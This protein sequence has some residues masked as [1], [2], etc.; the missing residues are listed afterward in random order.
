[1][2]FRWWTLPIRDCNIPIKDVHF[3][4]EDKSY[5]DEK[6]IAQKL[7]RQFAHPSARNLEAVMKNADAVDSEVNEIIEQFSDNCNVCKM[8]Q[9]TPVRP[10]VCMPV[11]NKFNEVVAM[12][13]KHFK[14]GAYLLHLIDLFSRFSLSKVITRKLPSVTVDALNKMWIA[15]GFG[16]PKGFLLDNGGEFAD[17]LY[18]EMTAHFNV[19]ICNTGAESPWQNGIC[20]RNHVVIDLCVENMLEDDQTLSLEVALAWVMNAKNS[21]SYETTLGFHHTN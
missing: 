14:D 6:R 9:R 17:N 4:I 20:N 16:A 15:S 21:I 1:M 3:S 13:L 5:V 8:F 2:E 10:V 18:E 11:A 12:D 7:H 19:E